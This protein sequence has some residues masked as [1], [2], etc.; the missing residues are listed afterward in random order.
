MTGRFV[1]NSI[2]W[3]SRSRVES[4]LACPA[5]SPALYRDLDRPPRGTRV[6]DGRYEVV[7]ANTL[8]VFWAIEAARLAGVP[9]VWS[10]HESEP[11]TTYFD[12]FPQQNAASALA[13]TLRTPTAKSSSRPRALRICQRPQARPRISDLWPLGVGDAELCQLE[14]AQWIAT[15]ARCELKV[16]AGT[17]LAS[18]CLGRCVNEKVNKTWSRAFGTR[19]D[20]IASRMRCIVV[21][22]SNT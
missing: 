21:G 5:A 1:G 7:H 14:P 15:A 4:T 20:Q 6:R 13:C 9:S 19:P 2:G 18:C 3:A 8:Q 10:V 16:G 12:D 22:G 11:W 17:K